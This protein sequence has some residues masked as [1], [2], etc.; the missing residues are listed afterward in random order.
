MSSPFAS[1][2]PS[3]T[4]NLSPTRTASLPNVSG[5]LLI[6]LPSLI[7]VQDVLNKSFKLPDI[8]WNHILNYN[9]DNDKRQLSL[10]QN[11]HFYLSEPKLEDGA[12][13]EK[14]VVELTRTRPYPPKT[15]YALT[16]DKRRVYLEF[17]KKR[18]TLAHVS[19]ANNDTLG[20]KGLYPLFL[21]LP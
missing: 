20:F 11:P 17:G 7:I 4:C 9:G 8:L 13:Q 16:N 18:R 12:Y 19:R 14:C 21:F 6:R 5:D 3:L 15:I 2:D 10:A 1:C